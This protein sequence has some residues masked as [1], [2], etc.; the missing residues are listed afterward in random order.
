MFESYADSF[1]RKSVGNYERALLLAGDASNRRYYRIYKNSK[2]YILCVDEQ[3]RNVPEKYY[4]Y[5]IVYDIFRREDIPVPEVYCKDSTNGLLLIED[6]GDD[7]LESVY[8]DLPPIKRNEIYTELIDILITIQQIRR[9]EEL[10]LFKLSF[11]VEKLMYEFKFFIENALVKHLGL[12]AGDSRLQE[13]T[14]EFVKISNILYRP[15]YF[16]LCHRDFHSRNVLLVNNRPYLIDFQD[17]R[18]GLPQYDLASLL[19]DSY[20]NLDNESFRFL[21]RYYY[22]Q[23]QLAG[24]HSMS[25][26]EFDY[27]FDII[28]F[29]R[30]I[31]AVGTFAYQASSLGRERYI[32]YIR[33][34]LAYLGDYIERST[35]L[36]MAGELLKSLIEVDW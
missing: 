29:Q 22:R 13:L 12:N 27:Y 21:T 25:N 6:L 17:A 34:T 24:I 32:K 31:K 18:M 26:D 19:R 28:A 36:R 1:I 23:S 3:F 5:N 30:N 10:P 16:V 35:E 8:P 7:L 9:V 15:E 33:P 4:P 11:D 14:A 2:S 20:L